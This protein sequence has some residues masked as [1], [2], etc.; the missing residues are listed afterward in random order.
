MT[1]LGSGLP[2]TRFRFLGDS[3][4]PGLLLLALF[5]P[6]PSSAKPLGDSRVSSDEPAGGTFL[7]CKRPKPGKPPGDRFWI[8][9]LT[10]SPKLKPVVPGYVKWPSAS[11]EL[12]PAGS[13]LSFAGNGLPEGTPTGHFPAAEARR[14]G[15]FPES[16][17]SIV[18]HTVGGAVPRPVKARRPGCVSPSRPLGISVNGVPLLPPVDRRGRDL[19]ARELTDSCGGGVTSGGLYAYR[20]LPACLDSGPGHSALIGYARD[21][22]PIFGPRGAGGKRVSRKRLDDCGGHAHSVNLG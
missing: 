2:Q 21:G 18:E 6:S 4:L 8:S 22:Y 14:L 7:S 1:G 10:W 5:A 11:F 20:G 9:G 3:I 12:T 19:V 13:G 15:A 17:R 16:Q